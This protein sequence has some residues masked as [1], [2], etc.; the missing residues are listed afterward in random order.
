MAGREAGIRACRAKQQSAFAMQLAC[1]DSIRSPTFRWR[2]SR[3]A[4][5]ATGPRSAAPLCLH[6]AHSF[7]AAHCS[8]CRGLTGGACA[9]DHGCHKPASAGC[10]QRQLVPRP[11][12]GGGR[13]SGS[14]GGGVAIAALESNEIG[15]AVNLINLVIVAD[16][17]SLP[18]L[19]VPFDSAS[20]A[21]WLASRLM[22]IR[23]VRLH[24]PQ[25]NSMHG[26]RW[27]S[28]LR[29]IQEA[30]NALHRAD[31]MSE[32]VGW[33]GATAHAAKRAGTPSP[34]RSNVRSAPR[35][36]PAAAAQPSSPS[37]TTSRRS[38]RRRRPT[39]P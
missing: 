6:P 18:L 7:Q 39:S 3:A 29:G 15:L 37:T 30:F 12:G 5:R 34:P 14:G 22:S 1:G 26:V 25:S 20:G 38:A 8:H 23:P 9:C 2:P 11:S 4:E 19:R 24:R 32:R 27:Q 17:V 35:P 36:H 28:V 10:H 13:A 16:K 21:H 33:Q 31:V